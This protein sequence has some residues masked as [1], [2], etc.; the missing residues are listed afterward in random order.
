MST[1]RGNVLAETEVMGFVPVVSVA[2]S[3]D[4]DK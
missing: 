3:V 1:S 2:L 4:G